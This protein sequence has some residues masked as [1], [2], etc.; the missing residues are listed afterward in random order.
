MG[1]ISGPLR[2]ERK[3]RKERIRHETINRVLNLLNKMTTINNYGLKLRPTYAEI[4]KYLQN[5]QESWKYPDRTAKRFRESPYLTQMDS[6]GMMSMEEQPLNR[7]KEES[8]GNELIKNGKPINSVIC[9]IKNR[10]S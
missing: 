6:E 8:K 5:S 2:A 9:C 7:I 10:T 3:T 4:I 1:I